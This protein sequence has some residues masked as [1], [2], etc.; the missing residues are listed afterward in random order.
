MATL[1][2]IPDDQYCQSFN[3]PDINNSIPWSEKS[4]RCSDNSFSLM[5]NYS[6]TTNANDTESSFG[7][8]GLNSFE[9]TESESI[10][11][12]W[13]R[14][15]TCGSPYVIPS[16]YSYDNT[17]MRNLVNFIQIRPQVGPFLDNFY[18]EIISLYSQP[19]MISLSL[20]RDSNPLSEELV[21]TISLS[22][23]SQNFEELLEQEDKLFSSLGG[24]SWFDDALRFLT[25]EYA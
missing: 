3:H 18:S 14:V 13:R 2:T 21:V 15:G 8:F 19:Y 10:G 5:P 4:S 25:I 9:P 23:I 12:L 17:E 1:S 6:G 20:F 24:T 22:D 11:A 7:T 16:C